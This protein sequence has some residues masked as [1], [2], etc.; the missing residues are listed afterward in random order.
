[1]VTAAMVLRK[2]FRLGL[3]ARRLRVEGPMGSVA[4]LAPPGVAA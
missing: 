4:P 2:L 3:V 1:M